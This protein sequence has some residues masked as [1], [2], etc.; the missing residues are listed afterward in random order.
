[1]VSVV[2][3]EISRSCPTLEEFKY[4]LKY[5]VFFKCIP[6]QSILFCF[7]L[8]HFLSE[9]YQQPSDLFSISKGQYDSQ[10][11]MMSNGDSLP[12]VIFF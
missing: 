12:N 8:S 9:L 3:D 7:W 2:K 10:I 4:W 11:R 1:V 5:L 6:L